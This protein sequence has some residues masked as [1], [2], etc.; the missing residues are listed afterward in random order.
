MF[1]QVISMDCTKE[2]YEKYLKDELLKMGYEEQW[3]C[4]KRK[5]K[6]FT[7]AANG[8]AGKMIDIGEGGKE[9]FNRTYLGSFNAELFL[10]LAAMTDSERIFGYREWAKQKGGNDFQL[11]QVGENC[12]PYWRKATK[13]EIMKRFGEKEFK[14]VD[15]SDIV[16]INYLGIIPEEGKYYHCKLKNGGKW[17]FIAGGHRSGK[18]KH[19][20][21]IN[22]DTLFCDENNTIANDNYVVKIRPA[23]NLE[24][25]KLDSELAKSG[26]YFDQ[27]KCEIKPINEKKINHNTHKNTNDESDAINLLKSKGYKILKPKTWEEI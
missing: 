11:P 13:E 22:L 23:T 19:I 9:R 21:A 4:W 1:T 25:E 5:I 3:M 8:V 16:P 27:D 6:I 18:T 24:K 14:L 17:V 15:K 7:N 2:Q 12:N 20:R 26:V 10:A